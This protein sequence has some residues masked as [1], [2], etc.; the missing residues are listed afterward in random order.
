MLTPLENAVLDMLL[1]R[2]G[3]PYETI[4]QQVSSATV[5]HREFT[6]VGFFTHFVLSSDAPVRRDLPNMEL[7]DIGA[8]FPGVKHDAGFLLFVRDGIVSMLEGYT[9]DENWPEN[10]DGF[11]VFRHPIPNP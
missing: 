9:Y 1:D 7:G 6:G 11:R 3:E 4:R 5:S 8:E 2:P 10:L